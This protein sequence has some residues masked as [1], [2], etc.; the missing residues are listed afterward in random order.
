MGLAPPD[1]DNIANFPRVEFDSQTG[2]SG[3]Q[4]IVCIRDTFAR[5]NAIFPLWRLERNPI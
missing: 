4:M 3:C 1:T 5:A 2:F